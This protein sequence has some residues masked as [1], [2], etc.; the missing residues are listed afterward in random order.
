MSPDR[1]AIVGKA[2]LQIWAAMSPEERAQ[3]RAAFALTRGGPPHRVPS[4]V[5]LDE[6][7]P[8]N[9]VAVIA[10]DPDVPDGRLVVISRSNF[11]DATLA[12][13]TQLLATQRSP[14]SE[15]GELHIARNATV[16]D[17]ANRVL[18]QLN[19]PDQELTNSSE[20]LSN[21][22]ATAISNSPIHILNLGGGRVYRFE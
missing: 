20:A 2:A 22:T 5:I 16:S 9:A 15:S 8:N 14:M 21:L 19:S 4:I 1:D 6:E 18:F 10:A 17:R 11:N 12:L 13:A 3:A 7:L